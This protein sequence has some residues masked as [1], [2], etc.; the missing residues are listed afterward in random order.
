[1]EEAPQEVIPRLVAF[2]NKSHILSI[3][4]RGSTSG[5]KA[6]LQSPLWNTFQGIRKASCCF[7]SFIIFLVPSLKDEGKMRLMY[8]DLVLPN[9][10]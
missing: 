10:L 2:I 7:P 3:S 1:M 9:L 4:D 5:S 8:S 6:V